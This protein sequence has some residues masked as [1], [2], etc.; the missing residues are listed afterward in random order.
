MRKPS[1]CVR[2]LV[3]DGDV[4]AVIAERLVHVRIVGRDGGVE[5]VLVVAIVAGDLGAVDGDFGDLALVGVVEQLGEADVLF[6][7][8]AG[9]P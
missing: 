7:T 4:D 3:L 5:L 6:L 9:C 2:V 1:H 8:G